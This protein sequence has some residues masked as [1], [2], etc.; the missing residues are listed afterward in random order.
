MN[1][2]RRL[3]EMGRE[4]PVKTAPFR[5]L[6]PF[7][8]HY[9]DLAGLQC[10]Y[11]DEGEGDPVV[12]LHGNPTW[13]F[14]YR[15]LVL[16]LRSRCR[17]IVPDHIGCGLS[18]K[19][20]PSRYGYRL[21]DRVADLELLL[22]RL[23]L[24]D[25]LTLVV[26]D[27]GGMIGMNFAVRHPGRIRRL[28]ITNTAA[29]FPPGGKSLPWQLRF[30]RNLPLLAAPLVLGF[31]AFA[32]AALFSATKMGLSAPV[33]RGLAAPYNGWRNRLATLRFVQDIPWRPQDPGYE[34]VRCVDRHLHRLA[35]K[36][37]LICWGK[38]DFVFDETYY[39]S[40][41]RRFPKA[42]AHW[43]AEAGHY[44]LEDVPEAVCARVETFLRKHPL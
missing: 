31:N 6:Y 32:V 30:V 24:R 2:R 14:Y 9:A 4:R 27:W 28:V 38:H 8:S 37:M 3:L 35:G 18:E 40:W 26:H 11:L 1:L 10:H 12:M 41:R 43:F 21:A 36:P 25:R 17:C 33:R 42:E 39:R 34:T 19:P 5:R 29:F 16:A 44:L 13:S 15:S 22:D 7:A 23:E 20:P